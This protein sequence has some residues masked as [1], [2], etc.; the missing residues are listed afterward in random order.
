[1]TK[2]WCG[3]HASEC[4]GALT[5]KFTSLGWLFFLIEELIYSV[6]FCCIAKH[7]SYTYM[8]F[9]I[10]LFIMICHRMGISVWIQMKV[11]NSL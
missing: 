7:F 1:M 5:R 4:P 11:K 2:D 8:F 6:N 10:F 9:F 3:V